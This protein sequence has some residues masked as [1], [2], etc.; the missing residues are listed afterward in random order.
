MLAKPQLGGG[1]TMKL[2]ST[3]SEP[4]LIVTVWSAFTATSHFWLG[5][6]GASSG[7]PS[8]RQVARPTLPSFL[9]R[10]PADLQ[11]VVHVGDLVVVRAPRVGHGDRPIGVWRS[12][13]LSD[14]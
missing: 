13:H 6:D 5:L 3:H 8:G 14:F 7:E 1:S 4:C 9:P 10:G 11:A 12:I 2:L